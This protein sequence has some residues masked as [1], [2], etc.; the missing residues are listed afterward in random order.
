MKSIV[1][2]DGKEEDRHQLVASI[3]EAA[4]GIINKLERI[5]WQHSVLQRLAAF[6]LCGGVY[7]KC[8]L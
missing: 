4:F 5:P 7:F 8:V 2:H 6:I 3:N 1:Y